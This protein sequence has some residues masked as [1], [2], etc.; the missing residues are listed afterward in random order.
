MPFYV[1]FPTD[2]VVNVNWKKKP[3]DPNDPGDPT[4]F[5]QTCGA[6]INGHSG[7]FVGSTGVYILDGYWLY[8]Q[9]PDASPGHLPTKPYNYFNQMEYYNYFLNGS[10]PYIWSQ[11]SSWTVT[12]ADY[13]AGAVFK[14]FRNVNIQVFTGHNA[15][16]DQVAT[17]SIEIQSQREGEV[18]PPAFTVENGSGGIYAADPPLVVQAHCCPKPGASGCNKFETPGYWPGFDASPGELM[19]M[20]PPQPAGWGT[21]FDPRTLVVYPAPGST[22]EPVRPPLGA[23]RR[24]EPRLPPPLIVPQRLE[25]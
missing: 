17:G 11:P 22:D 23:R 9:H 12:G 10:L 19:A 13:A 4:D 8:Q 1:E 15:A 7:S 25:V 2:P 20:A 5:R 24:A 21:F 3:D 6:F 16:P 14:E 18:Y